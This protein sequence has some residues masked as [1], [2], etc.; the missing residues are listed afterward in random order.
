[1][2]I[3]RLAGPGVAALLVLGLT[4]CAERG[5]AGS[6]APSS[7]PPAV[8]ADDGLVLRVE[9]TG[10]FVTPSTTLGRLPLV[11]VYA[12]GRV[13]TEGPVPAIY[14]GPALPNVQVAELDAAGVQGLVEQAVAAGVTD[15][16]DLG[17]PPVAD[18]PSTR[19]TL[20][21]SEG[22]HEREVYALWETP[23]EGSG[24]TPEQEDARGRLSDL[25]SSLTDA[26]GADTSSY[27]PESVA[28]VVTPWVDP[29]DGLVQP[30]LPWAGPALPGEPT[31][32]PPDVSCVTATGADAQRLLEAAQGANAATPWTTGDGLRWSVTFRPLLPDETGCADLGS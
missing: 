30:E 23:P 13:V 6:P 21:T 28:A 14:P 1:M 19:F 32:G 12:D 22:V 11:S 10:G 20:V 24:L 8:P 4:G 29:G 25:L 5:A 27:L 15:D 31:S 16:A 3:T 18:A 17:T 26:G 7:A 9:H 2:T